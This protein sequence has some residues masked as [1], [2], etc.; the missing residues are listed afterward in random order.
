MAACIP[1]DGKSFFLWIPAWNFVFEEC[2]SSTEPLTEPAQ[3]L[4]DRGQTLLF[5]LSN[6]EEKHST[7]VQ[8]KRK[9]ISSL[10]SPKKNSGRIYVACDLSCADT[11]SWWMKCSRRT[12]Q[13]C[14]SWSTTVTLA[15]LPQAELLC[16]CLASATAGPQ[17]AG[18][19]LWKTECRDTAQK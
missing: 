16:F 12:A 18:R 17:A 2:C 10:N 5:E 8:S 19:A 3:T 9:S 14:H 13:L 11:H 1:V 4:Q 6:S 15:Q 7:V